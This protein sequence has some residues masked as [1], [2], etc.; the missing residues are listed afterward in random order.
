MS[1]VNSIRRQPLF[2]AAIALSLAIAVWHAFVPT[3][4]NPFPQGKVF[5]GGTIVSEVEERETFYGEKRVSFVLEGKKIWEGSSAKPSGVSGGVKVHLRDPKEDLAYGDELVMQGELVAP[6]GLRNPGGFDQKAYLERQGIYALF[7][8]AKNAKLKLLKRGQGN[9]LRA[10]AIQAKRFL[11]KS[12]SREFDTRDASFLKALFLGER[13]DL[14]EDFKDLFIKTGTMHILAVS[15]FNI[16]F[17]GLTLFFLLK[18]FPVSL[19]AK[20]LVTL[21]LVWCYCL[22][23][24][25]QAPVV[26]A[27]VMASVFILGRLLG[28]KTNALNTLGFAALLILLVNPQQLFDVGF[29]LSFLAVFGIVKFT[30]VFVEKPKLLPN[31][32]LTLKEKAIFYSKELFWISFICLV[33]TLPVTVQNFYIVT[34]YSLI[35]NMVVVP[36]SFLL[37]FSG[38]LFFLTFWWLPPFLALIP[39]AMKILMKIFVGALFAIESVPGSSVIVGKLTPVL[40]VILAGG[41]FYLL[42]TARLKDKWRRFLAITLFATTVFFAQE[43]Y[44][45][46]HREFKMTVLDVGQGDAIYFEFPKGGNL[47]VDTGKGGDSDKGRW[48]IAPFLKSKG[49]RTLETV[50]ITH[51]HDDHL[52]GLPTVLDEFKV[53]EVVENGQ[54]YDSDIFRLSR[55]RIKNEKAKHLIVHRGMRLDHF[56]EVEILVINPPLGRYPDK[57]VNNASVVLKVIHKGHSFLLTGDVGQEAMVELLSSGEDVRATVLKVPHH[58][59]KFGPEGEAFVKAVNPQISVV[60]VGQ[61]NVYHHPSPKTLESLNLVQGNRVYRTDRD[62]AVE[63]VSDGESVVQSIYAK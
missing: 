47:L 62:A 44:R 14:E 30:P 45:Y 12:L 17:L 56:P 43:V 20:L 19:N 28:R 24:G 37:F 48:V 34:P 60:S 49:V 46:F 23:V 4:K 39:W 36:I 11:S 32:K 7:Y 31:E 52:G 50:A 51:P 15:G 22:I 55:E 2:Y 1:I 9:I 25:W 38:I 21:I 27:S 16:G 8:G 29:Q 41:L 26:R 63:I 35:A 3:A 58:G 57:D 42:F 53:K 6:K 13:S 61:R 10:K 5:L 40:W 54:A 33:V 59:G 18:P